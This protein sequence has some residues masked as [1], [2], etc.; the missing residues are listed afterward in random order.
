MLSWLCLMTTKS[1]QNIFTYIFT[2]IIHHTE[3]TTRKT[4]KTHKKHNRLR[5]SIVFSIYI[6]IYIFCPRRMWQEVNFFKRVLFP[7][8]LFNGISTFVGYF[9]P[10]PLDWRC[11]WCNCYRR[12]KWARRHE[13]KSWTW[14]IAF[15]IALIPSGKVWIQLFSLQLWV[16]SRTDWVL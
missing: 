1:I 13:F 6:Y 2:Y 15:R 4:G 11:P 16:N 10:K 9:M 14:P 8:S 7:V 3:T 5:L 12:W